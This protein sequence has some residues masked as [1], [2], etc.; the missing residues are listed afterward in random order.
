MYATIA[1]V[2]RRCSFAGILALSLLTSGAVVADPLPFP[3]GR[4]LQDL[5][6]WDA[7]G[8]GGATLANAV[9][10]GNGFSGK[11][12]VAG[13]PDEL[14]PELIGFKADGQ[15]LYNLALVYPGKM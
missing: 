15:H 13:V 9:I 7:Y 10:V 8:L 14:A 4:K 12:H 3:T 11:L 2:L 1:S 6:A 5:A